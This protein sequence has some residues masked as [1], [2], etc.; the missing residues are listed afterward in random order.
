MNYYDNNNR[1]QTFQNYYG[2]SMN[3][4]LL[5]NAPSWPEAIVQRSSASGCVC[6]GCRRRRCAGGHIMAGIRGLGTALT[7]CNVTTTFHC[8]RYNKFTRALLDW[9]RFAR[10]V[11]RRLRNIGG[12]RSG[13]GVRLW[14]IGRLTWQWIRSAPGKHTKYLRLMSALE[15]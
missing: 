5:P 15:S 3:Q 8:N 12:G 2:F 6:W 13:C 1:E 11:H 7:R 10:I 9:L 14:I 4:H